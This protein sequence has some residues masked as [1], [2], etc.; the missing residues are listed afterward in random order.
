VGLAACGG[1]TEIDEK[2]L[3]R[4]TEKERRVRR[5]REDH[6]ADRPT[7]K[8]GAGT[9]IMRYRVTVSEP[10]TDGSDI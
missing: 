3:Q 10:E 4:T 8:S 7:L 1:P 2:S 5:R 6:Q 9:S